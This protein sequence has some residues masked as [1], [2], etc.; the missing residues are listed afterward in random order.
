MRQQD[1]RFIL[2]PRPSKKQHFLLKSASKPDHCE[3]SHVLVPE[4]RFHRRNSRSD[5][6]HVHPLPRLD[7]RRELRLGRAQRGVESSHLFVVLLFLCV[8][9]HEFG[10]ILTARAFGVLTPDVILLPIGGVARLERIPEKPLEEFLIA[11]AGPLVNVVIAFGLTPPRHISTLPKAR[12]WPQCT[13]LG[14][15]RYTAITD[16]LC[17]LLAQGARVNGGAK[18]PQIADEHRATS[19]RRGKSSPHRNYDFPFGVSAFDVG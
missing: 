10:H 14:T 1:S 11:I 3:A 7:F 2:T 19:S 8:L 16:A 9:A 12:L 5:P 15:C 17:N 13:R 18:H 6:H 4:D